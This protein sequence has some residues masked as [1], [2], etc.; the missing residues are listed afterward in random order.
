MLETLGRHVRQNVVGYIALFVALGGT[1]Y[2]ATGGNF[3]LGQSNSASSTTALSAG[4]TGPA[5]RLTNMGTAPG[6]KALGLNVASGHAP[7]SVN[8]AT[9]VANLN[10]DRLDSID[11]SG[12]LAN[13]TGTVGSTNL[14]EG[15]V[16]PGKFGAIP[17]ARVEKSSNQSI[18]TNVGTIL[19]F[20]T[21]TFDSAGI[22]DNTTNNSR[23]T[24]PIDGVYEVSAGVFW[25][26][27]TES[28]ARAISLIENGAPCAG[29]CKAESVWPDTGTAF[30]TVQSVSTVL[31]LNAGDYMEAL[32]AQGSG[33]PLPALGAPRSSTF[34]AMTWVGPG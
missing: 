18:P 1:T 34:L 5:L 12:F 31:K 32:A 13:G 30:Q 24:A 14:A 33:G 29:G 4:P 23:L 11:S 27:A 21:E 7:L 28:G 2:A 8:S 26:D 16:T 19:N 6:A 22:H 3:I 17:A 15:A 25:D 9:K 10:A 20:D